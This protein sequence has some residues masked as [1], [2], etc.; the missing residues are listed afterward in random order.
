M[1]QIAIISNTSW[2]V[3]NFRK[4]LISN[5]V[6]LGYTVYAVC[7][8]D[9]F[10]AEIKALGCT[11][12]EL[13]GIENKGKNPFK[14]LLLC[15]ELRR[16]LRQYKIDYCY[17]YTPKINIYG[18][19]ATKFSK[20]QA[21]VT[22]NGLGL[23]FTDE[24]PGWLKFAVKKLY[25]FAFRHLSVV[26]FQNDEDRRFFI[27]AGIINQ[28]HRT[29]LVKGSGV[30]L[31][32]FYP[33]KSFNEGRKLVFLLSARLIKEKGLYEYFEAAQNLKTKYPDVTFALIGLPAKNP[34]AVPE[35]EIQAIAE[36]GTISY[37]GESD[38]MSKTLD[39]V[40]V[41]VLP[42]YYREGIPRILLEGLAKGLP[43]I[44]TDNIGC[45]ET[46]DH[47]QNGYLVPVKDATALEQAME[48]MIT[49]PETERLQMGVNSR[50]KATADFDEKVNHLA[51]INCMN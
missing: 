48:H 20:V 28:K 2:Y 24:Q 35:A 13:K 43:I 15:W 39:S 30:N 3:Y 27:K 33:K 11:F 21:I 34:S 49:L 40:D 38:N 1:K 6:Q 32:E 17:L 18:S 7:P 5:L 31:S 25:K 10:V 12:I 23:V 42:S 14:D 51:Y 47:G 8:K 26:F 45:R 29:Q 50:T 41:L 46:V 9:K 44:T 16:I 19:I 37:L 36:K 22:I 4:G